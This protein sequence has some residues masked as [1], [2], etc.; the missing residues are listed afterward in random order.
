FVDRTDD[1]YHL[2]RWPHVLIDHQ[3]FE[4][5]AT[6]GTIEYEEKAFDIYAGNLLENEATQEHF[7]P[8]AQY[9]HRL[10]L[11]TADKLGKTALASGS[12][13]RATRIAEKLI[14]IDP[15]NEAGYA[16]H[17]QAV[18]AVGNESMLKTVYQQAKHFLETNEGPGA[19]GT[20]DRLWKQLS[21]EKNNPS[22]LR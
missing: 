5:Y 10:F 8:Q 2:Q 4:E 21:E 13:Q 20:L 14:R 17:M 11:E 9:L 19:A 3:L 18:H 7:I 15:W 22:S 12:P 1:S 6:S 16:L